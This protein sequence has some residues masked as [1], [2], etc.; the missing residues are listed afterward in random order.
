MEYRLEEHRYALKIIQNVEEYNKIFTEF[1]RM[2]PLHFSE[3]P[4]FLSISLNIVL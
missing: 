3:F 2:L 1:C 4:Y